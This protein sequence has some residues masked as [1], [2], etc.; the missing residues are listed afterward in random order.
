MEPACQVI[1][2]RLVAYA[3][4]ELDA[5]AKAAVEAHLGACVP[6]S[7]ELEEIAALRALAREMP[8]VAS[9]AIDRQAILRRA[10]LETSRPRPVLSWL[11]PSDLVTAGALAAAV[12]LA[13]LMRSDRRPAMPCS[14]DALTV[15]ELEAY[16]TGTTL[17]RTAMHLESIDGMGSEPPREVIR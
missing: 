5:A 9:E 1:R 13:V 12:A 8:A 7:R 10:R 16:R 2:G 4:G 14:V 3:D 15:A 6:C 11:R 17:A